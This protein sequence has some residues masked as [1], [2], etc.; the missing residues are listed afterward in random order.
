MSEL[1][2]EICYMENKLKEIAKKIQEKVEDMPMKTAF[3]VN[4]TLRDMHE[5]LGRVRRNIGV[6]IREIEKGIRRNKEFRKNTYR[7][8]APDFSIFYRTLRS[9]A[10]F[11]IG[12]NKEI[13][14]RLDFY[15]LILLKY[16]I[17]TIKQL[18]VKIGE[19]YG[20]EVKIDEKE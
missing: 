12:N 15:E 9:T 8:N 7:L 13:T 4:E 3:V 14:D 16:S 6:V 18:V 5:T 19:I 10:K 20:V 17:E 1:I 2:D 11:E